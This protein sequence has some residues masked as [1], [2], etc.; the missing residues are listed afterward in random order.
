MKLNT[1]GKCNTR[2]YAETNQA[3]LIL[4]ASLPK[5]RQCC[6]NVRHYVYYAV[7]SS[8]HYLRFD[9]AEHGRARAGERG[10][11]LSNIFPK[12][13]D[14]LP[15][16]PSPHETG[17]APLSSPLLSAIFSCHC[18]RRRRLRHPSLGDAATAQR[19][20]PKWAREAPPGAR[21]PAE[22]CTTVLAAAVAAAVAASEGSNRPKKGAQ[23]RG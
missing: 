2:F 16:P 6:V 7:F 23:K 14:L 10:R 15:P 21:R 11:K 5:K 3:T 9:R 22:L 1:K 18:R 17:P 13:N 12:A 19:D 8:L 20:L 4:K